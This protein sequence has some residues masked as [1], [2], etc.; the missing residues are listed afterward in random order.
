MQKYIRLGDI[1]GDGRVD[2]CALNDDGSMRC[3]RNGGLA[4]KC[5]NWQAMGLTFSEYDFGDIDGVRLVDINGDVS[6]L[7]SSRVHYNV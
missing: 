4:D 7:F 3:W 6:L 5:D 1:D 2:Y